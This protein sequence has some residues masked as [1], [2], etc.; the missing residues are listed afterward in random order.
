M[1]VICF[2]IYKKKYAP[3]AYA[4]RKFS[5]NGSSDH[6]SVVDFE[7][8]DKLLGVTVFSYSQLEE[9]TDNFNST[10]ELGDGGFG[11]VYYGKIQQLNNLIFFS[12][13]DLRMTLLIFINQASSRMGALLQSSVCMKRI[14]R[15]LN[16]S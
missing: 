6:S 2:F 11:T 7:K 8:A 10:Q 16:N 12:Y 3:S 14:T 4:S 13:L 1:A 15:E 5:S 9:A